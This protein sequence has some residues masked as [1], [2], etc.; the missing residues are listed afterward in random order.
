MCVC[1]I[2]F[3][4]FHNSDN[5]QIVHDVGFPFALP[6]LLALR[7]DGESALTVCCALVVIHSHVVAL[8]LCWFVQS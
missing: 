5:S 4:F 6:V 7:F 3:Y 8:K 2:L 1:V